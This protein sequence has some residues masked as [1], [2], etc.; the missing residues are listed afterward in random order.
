V[1][2]TLVVTLAAA[3][4]VSLLWVFQRRLIYLPDSGPVPS[5]AGLL[6]GGTDVVISTD[7]GLELRAW[8]VPP[9]PSACPAVFLVAPGNAGNS[10]ARVGLVRALADA[11][12]GVL[13]MEYRG[14]GNNPG[15]PSEGGL[16]SDARAAHAYLTQQA[17]VLASQLVYFGESLGGAVV[18]RL[19]VD[20]P[21]AAMVL[22]SPF[23]DLA[24]AA[25][26]H[27]PFLPV[28]LLLRDH[29]PV[30]DLVRTM[31]TP[32]GV[33]Y[34]SADSVVPSEQSAQVAA[35]AAGTGG[36]DGAGSPVKVFP[37]EGADHNDALLAQ[38]PQVLAAARWAASFVRCP[39]GR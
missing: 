30:A 15:S 23:A 17:G 35:A 29:F 13:L 8:Y 1:R 7:D 2:V 12:S 22:R 24:A 4:V 32:I 28:R 25:G 39:P 9:P 38:G 34:G 36:P 3:V 31:S 16:A 26:E 14:Y 6:P 37:V 5:A 20:H 18:T 11:G 10:L 27:Y 21:P 33:V 19:A